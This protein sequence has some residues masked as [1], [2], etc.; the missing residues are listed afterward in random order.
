MSVGIEL[1]E[2]VP[3]ERGLPRWHRYADTKQLQVRQRTEFRASSTCLEVCSRH[4]PDAPAN[5]KKVSDLDR[6]FVPGTRARVNA[7]IR[8]ELRLILEE[9]SRGAC[10]IEHITR[11]DRSI[12]DGMNHSPGA[13]LCRNPINSR[14]PGHDSRT[15][16]QALD[17]QDVVVAY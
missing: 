13:Q 14:L 3:P 2:E 9:C 16:K 7:V 6:E 8:P 4:G 15:A 10:D 5:P 17:P 1:R 12:N 11:R